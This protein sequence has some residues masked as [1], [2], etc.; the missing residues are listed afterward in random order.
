MLMSKGA[1]MSDTAT[2]IRN[3]R[4]QAGL[5]QQQLADRLVIP[6]PAV[7]AI[8]AGARKVSADELVVLARLFSVTVDYIVGLEEGIK[9]TLPAPET[10]K[11]KQTKRPKRELRINVPRKHL[12]KFREVLIYMLG[13]VGARPNI[14]ETVLY[15]LLYFIDFDYYEK[16]EEQIIGATYI[17]NHYGPTPVEFHEIVDRMMADGEITRI[18]VPHYDYQQKKYIPLRH[19]DLTKLDAREI[20]MIDDVLARLADM[21]ARQISEYSHN[22]IPWLTTEDGER[23]EYETVFYRTPQYSVRGYEDDEGKA[24]AVS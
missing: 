9:V 14:G 20:Q 10:V 22:D 4:E 11:T 19:P 6:R 5:N 2:R 8:E 13:A 7:S 24:D 12:D 1:R 15:K 3:L 23:I 17:K 18:E 16:Y 21:G